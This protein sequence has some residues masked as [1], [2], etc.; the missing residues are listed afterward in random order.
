ML[1][2]AL[3]RNTDFVYCSLVLRDLKVSRLIV[4]GTNDHDM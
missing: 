2:F 3:Y 4:I 1:S